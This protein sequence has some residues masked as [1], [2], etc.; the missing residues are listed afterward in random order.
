MRFFDRVRETS[1]TTGTGDLI[2][3]GAVIGYRT[4]AS[5]LTTNDTCYYCVAGQGTGE[6]EGGYGT[7]SAANTLTRTKVEFSSNSGSPVNFSAGTKDVFLTVSARRFDIIDLSSATSDYLLLPGESAK[8]AF[9]NSN[10]VALH[11]ETQEGIY[12]LGLYVSRAYT[13]ADC[14]LVLLPN[15]TSYTAAFTRADLHI[16][17]ASTDTGSHTPEGYH[18]P[19][20]SFWHWMLCSGFVSLKISTFVAAKSTLLSA[21][22][23]NSAGTSFMFSSSGAFW[24]D[25]TT[26][27]TSLGTLRFYDSSAYQNRS[28]TAI[29]KRIA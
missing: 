5:V 15:N 28:G 6:F 8:V 1:T 18:Y 10:S 7:Y 25:L 27:W 2:L 3:A 24:S 26:A 12:E 20:N 11:V 17:R 9:S 22:T 23:I 14:D 16:T 4:F 21:N 29:I 19:L 13:T